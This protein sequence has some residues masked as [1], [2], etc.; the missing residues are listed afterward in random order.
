MHKVFL[1][2]YLLHPQLSAVLTSLHLRGFSLH[3]FAPLQKD[4]ACHSV[5]DSEWEVRRQFQCSWSILCQEGPQ[6]WSFTFFL[7]LPLQQSNPA[8]CLWQLQSE[9]EFPASSLV[10]ADLCFELVQDTGSK[11]LLAPPSQTEGFTFLPPP[12]S[13]GLCLG[14]GLETSSHL[15]QMT[16]AFTLF[17]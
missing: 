2:V 16:K 5:P 12:E 17:G 14:L 4:I 13:K 8:L 11:S 1:S 9:E 15:S 10:A 3:T 6:R 7:F